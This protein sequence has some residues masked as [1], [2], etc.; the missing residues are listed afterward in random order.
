MTTLTANAV[1]IYTNTDPKALPFAKDIR[2]F[3]YNVS[4]RLSPQVVCI[5]T[6]QYW[7]SSGCSIELHLSVLPR[8]VVNVGSFVH[9]I[10]SLV[11]TYGA[12]SKVRCQAP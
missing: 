10:K 2:P 1:T 5:S 6:N 4:P 7:N 11:P 9:E 3:T 12:R 8:A